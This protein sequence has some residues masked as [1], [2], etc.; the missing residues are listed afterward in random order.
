MI[1]K[2]CYALERWKMTE[3]VDC[4]AVALSGG[5]DS[6]SLLHVL[7]SLSDKYG[8]SMRAIHVHHGIRGED[9]DADE[10]FCRDLCEKMNIPIDVFHFNV[11]EIAAEQGKGL[12]ECGRDC[13]YKCFEEIHSI[14]NCAI[15]TAHTLSDSA[16]TVLMNIARGCGI[17]GV[18]GIP[19]VRDYI[20]RPLICAARE[21]I[22]KYCSDNNLQYVTDQT[23]FDVVY[24]RNRIRH[25]IIPQMK[26]LNPEFMQSIVRLNESASNDEDYLSSQAE[27]ILKNAEIGKNKWQVKQLDTLH[28]ALK[29]RVIITMITE[30]CGKVPDFTHVSL[31][32]KLLSEKS[33][34]VSLSNGKNI[35]V[36]NGV[37]GEFVQQK[38]INRW[39]FKAEECVSLPCGKKARI[40][41][42]TYDDFVSRVKKD[43]SLFKN[44]IA[45]DIIKNNALI[46]N[47]REGDFFSQAGRGAGKKIKKLFNESKVPIEKRE[48]LV[49]LEMAGQIVWVEGFGAAEGMNPS[50]KD[51]FI[52]LITVID[53]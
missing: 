44:A 41:V 46:R 27:M 13:R 14:H 4:I 10:Q 11:P 36:K 32:E 40:E 12:E 8:Y 30:I 53:T 43:Q 25:E 34:A 51:Q 29:N 52:S 3:N 38:T 16:E 50:E 45:C 2:V 42:L 35:S 49:I 39:E 17:A 18:R 28:P 19:P 6:V 22:E 9:A 24:N 26:I 47:R 7:D 31:T 23:N 20:I 15:A 33:G 21:D 37:I 48:E 1:S 5:A